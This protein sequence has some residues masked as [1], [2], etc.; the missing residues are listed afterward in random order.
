[1]QALKISVFL[2]IIIQSIGSTFLP[3]VCSEKGSGCCTMSRGQQMSCCCSAAKDDL[4]VSIVQFNHSCTA[5]MNLSVGVENAVRSDRDNKNDPSQNTESSVLRNHH[6]SIDSQY[7][8][9]QHP[10]IGSAARSA[11]G[12]AKYI[13]NENLLI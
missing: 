10:C 13:L 7:P 11:P 8:F 3:S 4:S 2:I 12:R 1:M 5:G 6:N 9:L